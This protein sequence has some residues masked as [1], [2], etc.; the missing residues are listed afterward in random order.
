[1]VTHRANVLQAATD[2]RI[3]VLHMAARYDSDGTH[4]TFVARLLDLLADEPDTLRLLVEAEA[5]MHDPSLGIEP[6][7]MN[8]VSVACGVG[9]LELVS[10]LLS[11]A[12][13]LAGAFNSTGK[14]S[15]VT[16]AVIDD[17][18]ELLELLLRYE[19]DLGAQDAQGATALHTAVER[20]NLEA[21]EALLEAGAD[22]NAPDVYGQ[23]ALFVGLR[24]GDS[25]A[26][27]AATE[28]LLDH[29]A[30]ACARDARGLTV[31]SLAASRG[32]ADLLR[33]LLLPGA[34]G[35]RGVTGSCG[36]SCGASP[37]A[38]RLCLDAQDHGGRTALALAATSGQL[39]CLDLLMEAGANPLLRT[40]DGST[41]LGLFA[42]LGQLN[43][44]EQP[45]DLA[46]MAAK[47]AAYEAAARRARESERG[48]R[49]ALVATGG[50]D[51]VDLCC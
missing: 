21:A 27:A 16:Q 19:P 51:Q 32:R 36:C 44:S 45:S 20:C 25:Q 34:S 38:P 31:L 40:A 26:S 43:V 46:A 22:P 17:D 28:L 14:F 41:A 9:A 42:D 13:D 10:L 4:A 8:A 35:R 15:P 48:A 50:V 5:E 23:H 3:T 18:A 24:V 11:V 47:L 7:P 6:A 1:V 33:L 29:G 37:L 2:A 39:A 12:P 30:D 49:L